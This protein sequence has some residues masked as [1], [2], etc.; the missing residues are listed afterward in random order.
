MGG[1]KQTIVKPKKLVL[2]YEF[3]DSYDKLS[4]VGP[5][6]HE[7]FYS[8][9]KK[10]NISKEEYEEYLIE[11]KKR[12]C[13]TMLDWLKEYNLNDVIPFLEALEKQGVYIIQTKLIY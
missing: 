4:H 7:D 9:L 11:F 8:S 6:K 10:K 5:V 12:G 13:V 1:A 3:L 2:P